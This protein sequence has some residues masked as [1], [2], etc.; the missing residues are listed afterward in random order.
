ME[1]TFYFDHGVRYL[2]NLSHIEGD[3]AYLRYFKNLITNTERKVDCV[4]GIREVRKIM[5]NGEKYK[6]SLLTSF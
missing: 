3:R 4:F 6:Q 5:M 1:C 2:V